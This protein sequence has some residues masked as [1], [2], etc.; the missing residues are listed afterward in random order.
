MSESRPLL[1][2]PQQKRVSVQPRI[3]IPAHVAPLSQA[4]DCFSSWRKTKKKTEEAK[5]IEIHL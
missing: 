2:S 3:R 1:G 5:K 4:P